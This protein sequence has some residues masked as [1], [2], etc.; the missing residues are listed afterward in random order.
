[1]IGL[2]IV[3]FL[4]RHNVDDGERDVG[5]IDYTLTSFYARYVAM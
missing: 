2:V 4:L 3:G 5:F 1:M